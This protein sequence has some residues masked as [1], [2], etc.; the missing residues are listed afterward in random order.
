MKM[1]FKKYLILAIGVLIPYLSHAQIP[2]DQDCLGA[3]PVC[4]GFYTQVNSYSGSGNYPNEIPTSGSCPGNC[5]NSGEKNCVWYYVT[6]QSDGNMGFVITP[7]QGSDDYDWAVYDLTD[8]RCEDIYSQVAQLQVSCNW[9][10]TSGSTGPNGNS[11][12]ACQGASGSPYC[13]LIP[14]Q[15]GEIYVINISNYSSTQYG[16][17][18]DFSMSTA[19]IYDDVPPVVD[20]VFADAVSGCNTNELGILFSENVRC[21]RVTPVS[22]EITGPGGPYTITDIYGVACD[23]GGEW[24]KEFTLYVDPPFASNGD[25]ILHM[26]STFPGVVDA[27]DNVMMDHDVPFTLNLGAPTLNSLGVAISPA[28]CGMDNGSITGLSATGQTAL[29]YVWK[30]SLGTVVGNEI[31]LVDVPAETY[32]LEVHDLQFCTTYGGPWEVE[33][34]G[35]PEID[36]NGVSIIPANFGANNG[37][38]SGIIVSSSFTIAEY[39]WMDDQASIVGNDLD[40]T[41]VPTGYYTLEVIDENTCSAI[42]G[43]YF[44]GEIG[45]PLSANPSANPAIICSG[46]QVTLSPG[47]GGGSGDYTYSWTSIPAGFTSTLENPVVNPAETTTYYVDLFDGYIYADGEVTVTVRPIPMPDAGDDQTIAHGISTTLYGSAYN[48]SGSYEYE[49]APLDKLE[50]AAAQNPQTKNLYETTPFYLTVEDVETGCISVEP[51]QVIVEITGGFLNTNP[52]SFPDSVFCV[53]ETFTL[54]ANGGGGSG[55]YTFI[56]SCN[57]PLTLPADPSFSMSLDTPGDYE[58][59]VIID[60]GYNYASGQVTVRIEA[61]PTVE[62]GAAVQ[63]YCIY[64]TVTLD[65]GNPGSEYLWS[66]GATTQFI[67]IGTTGLSYDEQEFQVDVINAESCEA[68]DAVTIIFDYEACVGIAEENLAERLQVFPNPTTGLLNIVLEG[69]QG[70]LW[71]N[72]LNSTGML[73]GEYL[74]RPDANGNIKGNINLGGS[75][76]GIYLL[77]IDGKG[78]HKTVNI[79]VH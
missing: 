14:V 2:T 16:Y 29:S 78:I 18:L 42:S 12:A 1:R 28:T 62:L 53:D 27:C 46:D 37:S 49:W 48:G 50:D 10:G 74:F 13:A 72:V 57:P 54:H 8:A 32:T 30:N 35:A 25:Y 61:L 17:T 21:D 79:I 44:V 9:S 39:I 40:L 4:T 64:D 24:E 31:D 55:D 76:A 60:D 63:T 75:P 65:A 15:E 56:W 71:V 59:E 5:M 68:S 66:N 73:F 70:E 19:Q 6:V 33:E 58:F 51:D 22:F 43:P 52:S 47:A 34:F 67:T 20:E 36:D 7:N 26:Y 77:K 38:V 41:G 45:G 3:I 69:A 11:G 23:V